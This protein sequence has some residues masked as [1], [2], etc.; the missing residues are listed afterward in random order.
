[1]ASAL[2]TACAL[3]QIAGAESYPNPEFLAKIEATQSFCAQLNP[4]TAKTG[5]AFVAAL[6][7]QASV[8]ELKK[9]RESDEYRQAYDAVSADLASADPKLAAQTCG[10]DLQAQ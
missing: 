9:A 4:K 2:C 1:M 8:E 6:T 10:D 3:A 5:A 7:G